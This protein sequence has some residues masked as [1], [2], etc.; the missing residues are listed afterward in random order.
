M[1]SLRESS[2]Q[3]PPLEA[4]KWLSVC[5]LIDV[6]EMR[7][8]LLAMQPCLLFI[9]G[10]VVEK[11]EGD[12]SLESFL[13]VYR[14]Y[15][16]RLKNGELPLSSHYQ[17][18]FSSVMTTSADV[19][20]AVPVG[21][22]R[23]IVRVAKPVVQMQPSNIDYSPLEKKF[24]AN[25]FGPNTIPWGIQYSYPQLYHESQTKEIKKTNDSQEHPN[26]ALFH[27][28]Q[29]WVRG[30]TIPT[31]FY[32]D[33]KVIHAPFRLGKGCLSWINHHPR[34]IEKGIQVQA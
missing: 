34:L 13:D 26:T 10:S 31:P 24:R 17:K 22:D 16:E 7:D 6:D 19:L 12:L 30:H 11:G 1:I 15:I 9:S 14:D 28:L 29:K 23:Q 8:L 20:F 5:L 32:V 3:E 27:I 2:Y 33:G 18:P 21:G 4:S 25:V